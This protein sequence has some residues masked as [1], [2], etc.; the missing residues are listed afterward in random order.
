MCYTLLMGKLGEK[1]VAGYRQI[2]HSKA[3][4][5]PDNDGGERDTHWIKSLNIGT[6]MF[7]VLT[8]TCE[9]TTTFEMIKQDFED[10]LQETVG[11]EG[12]LDDA[13]IEILRPIL[14]KI[15]VKIKNKKLGYKNCYVNI[16]TFSHQELCL[17]TVTSLIETL[18]AFKDQCSV[19]EKIT[20]S[21]V[22]FRKL[23]SQEAEIEYDNQ[24]SDNSQQT[25][26]QQ[27]K[28]LTYISAGIESFY[29]EK[30]E[31][32]GDG[33]Q[34]VMCPTLLAQLNIGSKQNLTSRLY[35]VFIDCIGIDALIKELE[36]KC[37]KSLENQLQR[38][39][40]FIGRVRMDVQKINKY[41]CEADLLTDYSNADKILTLT[42]LNPLKNLSDYV[43]DVTT[44]IPP[45]VP[46]K[47]LLVGK[48][49]QG[50]ST[51]GNT[52]LRK[53]A[54]FKRSSSTHS[55]T[56]ES[57]KQSEI[58]DGRLITVVDTPGVYDT[59][60]DSRDMSS[61]AH[62]VRVISQGITL[63]G[64]GFDAIILVIRYGSRMTKEEKAVIEMMKTVLGENVIKTHSICLFTFGDTIENDMTFEAWLRGEHDPQFEALIKECNYRCV[65][66]DNRTKDSG[67][68]LDQ[69]RQLIEHVD[70]IKG[71]RYTSRIFEIAENKR[72]EY[73]LKNPLLTSSYHETLNYIELAIDLLTEDS[74]EIRDEL[75]LIENII[76]KT[77]DLCTVLANNKDKHSVELIRSLAIVR[78]EISQYSRIE[79]PTKIYLKS[80]DSIKKLL[81]TL[82]DAETEMDKNVY[83]IVRREVEKNACFPGEAIIVLS[84]GKQVAMMN[85]RVGDRV[86]SRDSSGRLV[87][88]EVYMFG[89]QEHNVTSHFIT[90]HTQA[91]SVSV[92]GDHY[93]FCV[94][95]GQEKC[96]PAKHLQV[97]DILLLASHEHLI[98]VPI[99]EITDAYDVGLYAPFT[100][101][102]T[103]VVNST[104]MSCYIHFLSHNISHQLLAPVRALHTVSPRLLS[105][106]NTFRD[107]HT[108]PLWAK[109]FMGLAR[110]MFA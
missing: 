35:D 18:T 72:K 108:V 71:V 107:V 32:S 62:A 95:R 69:M 12:V 29:K 80:F 78:E 94:T 66:F 99:T 26:F 16:K 25:R 44:K 41:I 57:S 96:I 84:S 3:P 92:T 87:Y 73:I 30:I 54:V 88:E 10:E 33:Q 60:L 19:L 82:R 52:I 43:K 100:R 14:S 53:D 22:K 61:I 20:H 98:H 40:E 15:D 9:D 81:N 42:R 28:L 6:Q 103:I 58:I 21:N 106:V 37:K 86:L 4:T 47:L 104:L 13:N 91:H 45:G 63:C 36:V 74:H 24:T 7:I 77:E 64:V 93:V 34:R 38:N 75:K 65:M 85:L 90:L 83:P 59:T 50:K 2:D 89:H 68:R 70:S 27:D 55:E 67:T 102:G 5:T 51:C 31:I 48:T 46:L 1:D 11:S 110:K 49:G 17:K 109:S 23:L 8:Y 56:S 101:N 97:G 79:K 39:K 76:Q 105:A